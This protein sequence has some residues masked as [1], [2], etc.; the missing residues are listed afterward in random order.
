MIARIQIGPVAHLVERVI[1]I[2][3]ASGSS[4]LGSTTV[5]KSALRQVFRL[6]RPEYIVSALLSPWARNDTRRGREYLTNKEQRSAF[7]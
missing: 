3:E 1:R 2:D 4:P 5:K 6:W 7:V